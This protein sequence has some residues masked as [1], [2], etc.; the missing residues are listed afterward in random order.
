M[1]V[2]HIHSVNKTRYTS[3]YTRQYYSLYCCVAVSYCVVCNGNTWLYKCVNGSHAVP[4][5]EVS[6]DKA[7]AGQVLHSSGDIQ[8]HCQRRLL[9]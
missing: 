6:V 2:K 1:L 7:G 9:V 4:C 3:Y 5:S 8:T